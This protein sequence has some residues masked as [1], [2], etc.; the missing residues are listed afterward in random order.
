MLRDHWN[1]WVRP[2]ARHSGPSPCA[3]ASHREDALPAVRAHHQRRREVLRELGAEAADLLAAP[4]CARRSASRCSSARSRRCGRPASARAARP[5]RSSRPRADHERFGVAV[6][7]ARRGDV[8]DMRVGERRDHPAQVVGH[9]HVIGV[10]LGDDVVQ[11]VAP[12]CRRRRRG[13]PPCSACAAATTAGGTP[14]TPSR[15]EIRTPC[16]SHQARVSG[17]RRARRRARRHRDAGSPGRASPRASR[18]RPATARS[19]PSSRS[20]PSAAAGRRA[21]G[22]GASCATATSR[23]RSVGR[24]ARCPAAPS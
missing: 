18:A 1:S 5:R 14:S 22:P 4:R 20:S 17:A 6:A 23:A 12:R 7:D 9:R 11:A 15:V 2:S 13:C 8:A 24:G 19:A 3:S 16:S 21:L 10:E